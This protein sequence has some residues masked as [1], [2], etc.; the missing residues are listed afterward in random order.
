MFQ[1]TITIKHVP[2]TDSWYST[3]VY[4]SPIYSKRLELWDYLISIRND[5]IDPWLMMEDFNETL[6]P[7]KQ[8]GCKFNH[9]KANAFLKVVDSCNLVDVFT[10]G[11]SYTW[12]KKCVG[13]RRVTKKFDR[14]LIDLHWRLVIPWRI[15][16]NDLQIENHSH[17]L[18]RVLVSLKIMIIDPSN[19]RQLGQLI[20]ITISLCKQ[21]GERRVMAL[22]LP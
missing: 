4:A 6:L 20:W 1:D 11:G 19:L 17:L 22:L 9:N 2:R 7:R 10:L 18:L 3:G 16:R 21:L 5:I 14:G 13:Q 8:S 15:C 12:S